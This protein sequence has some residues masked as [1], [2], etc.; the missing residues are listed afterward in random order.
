MNNI[1]SLSE[2]GSGRKISIKL[3]FSKLQDD[4]N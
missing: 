3:M 1:L 4:L 2:S